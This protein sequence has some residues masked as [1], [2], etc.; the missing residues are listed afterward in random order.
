MGRTLKKRAKKHGLWPDTWSAS[1]EAGEYRGKDFQKNRAAA[2]RKARKRVGKAKKGKPWQRRYTRRV[3]I[4]EGG[5]KTVFW[6]R[7]P[8]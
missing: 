1:C 3:V 8:T 4:G 7:G 2:R 5:D 6:D